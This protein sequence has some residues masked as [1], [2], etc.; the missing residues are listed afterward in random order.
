MVRRAVAG[1]VVKGDGQVHKAR[2]FRSAWVKGTPPIVYAGATGPRMMD[3][4][5]RFADGTMLSDMILPMLPRTMGYVRAGLAKYG[6]DPTGFR[7]N[8]FCAFHIK[9]EREVSFIEARREL[10]PRLVA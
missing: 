7:V 4:A 1:Q 6:R 5:T 10:I 8:N 9:D 3:M 2:H